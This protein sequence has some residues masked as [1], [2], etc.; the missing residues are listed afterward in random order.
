VEVFEDRQK[1]LEGGLVEPFG[2]V[3]AC[4]RGEVSLNMVTVPV[5]MFRLVNSSPEAMTLSTS[6]QAVLVSV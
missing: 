6:R 1:L 5:A 4:L 3:T 2:D